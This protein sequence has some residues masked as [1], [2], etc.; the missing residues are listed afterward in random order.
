MS[1][2]DEKIDCATIGKSS[3]T[4]ETVRLTKRP[5]VKK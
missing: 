3:K 2:I 4:K 1:F 5:K